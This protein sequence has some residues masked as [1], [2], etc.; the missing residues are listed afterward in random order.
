MNGE[1]VYKASCYACRLF[2]NTGLA[3]R[4]RVGDFYPN[5]NPLTEVRYGVAIDRVTGAVAHGPFQLETVTDGSFDG[6][7]TLR[8]FTLGQLGLTS[9]AL[10]DISD[11]LVPLG[12]GK[13]RGLGRVHLEFRKA[14]FRYLKKPEGGLL[15]A[16][17]IITD[18]SMRAKYPLPEPEKDRMAVKAQVQEQKPFFVLEVEG[19]QTRQWLENTVG[20]WVDEVEDWKEE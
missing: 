19:E 16:G 11:G 5:G 6:I 9:A 15:G 13:S 17:A 14:T 12:H 2:G 18:E 4:I 7:I 3:A 8:N 20:R 10:L 1:Q